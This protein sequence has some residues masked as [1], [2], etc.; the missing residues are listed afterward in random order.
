MKSKKMDIELLATII[1]LANKQTET[2]CGFLHTLDTLEQLSVEV[3][4]VLTQT[5]INSNTSLLSITNAIFVEE[6]LNM[7]NNKL[8]NNPDNLSNLFN[9]SNLINT[10]D[11]IV[12]SVNLEELDSDYQASEEDEDYDEYYD[13]DE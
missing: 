13:D 1:D 2:I 11:T 5:L 8:N 6:L 4:S 3:E 10:P 9:T 7:S 12:H